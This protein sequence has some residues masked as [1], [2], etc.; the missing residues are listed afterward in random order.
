M[1][2][3]GKFGASPK[4]KVKKAKEKLVPT[5]AHDENADVGDENGG[6]AADNYSNDENT[7]P[8]D[9]TRTNTARRNSLHCFEVAEGEV[10]FPD[11]FTGWNDPAASRE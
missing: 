7:N 6:V 1:P 9:A 2:R 3:K 10:G 4:P 11:G 8:N 5:T